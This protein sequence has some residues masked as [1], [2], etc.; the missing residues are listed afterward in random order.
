MPDC[1]SRP[2]PSKRINYIVFYQFKARMPDQVT[3][4]LFTPREKLSKHI[5]ILPSSIRRVHRCDPINP[6]PPVTRILFIPLILLYFMFSK[7]N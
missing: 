2:H 1:I 6:A 7:N 5:T 4:I 3:Y